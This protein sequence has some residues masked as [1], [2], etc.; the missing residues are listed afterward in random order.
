MARVARTD[1]A[2]TVRGIVETPQGGVRVPAVLT[3]TGVLPYAD[4]AGNRWREL[5]P[6]DEVFAEDSLATL[7]DAPV[8]ELHPPGLVT[9]DTWDQVAVGHN[10]GG[11]RVEGDHLVVTDGLVVQS[12]P[13]VAK[14]V[15]GELCE[16]SAGYTCDLDE[17]PGVYEGEAYDKVQRRI[18][19]NHIALG[20][21]GWAR[22]GR[23]M[24]LRMD[25]AVETAAAPIPEALS[26]DPGTA[27]RSDSAGGPAKDNPTMKTLKLKGRTFRLDDV[28]EMAEAQ[29]TADAMEGEVSTHAA[30]NASISG[31]LSATKTALI[32]VTKKLAAL[33][34]QIA[35][36]EKA[37]AP[38]VTEDDVPEAV[39]DSIV[40]K[41]GVLLSTA[42][43][44][45]PTTVKLD[46]LKAAEIKR[47]VVT[48]VHPTIKLD[49]LGADTI[50]GLY[51]GATAAH[52][53][54]AAKRTDSQRALADVA[55][56]SSDQADAAK[57]EDS[58]AANHS[59]TLQDR[60][61][62]RGQ[63]PLTTKAS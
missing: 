35:A 51:L 24:A 28:A 60:L 61:I 42:K 29:K 3:R 14:V 21:A 23:E 59:T 34:V 13:V 45:L 17:T 5:R 30:A 6:A 32:E 53:S 10:S 40:A 49:G 37:E 41:R 38:A 15:S 8:T 63:T 56:P 48:H 4:A 36:E 12:A 20:P 58:A 43:S 25:G 2:G 11:A 54:Q 47:A 1:F 19:Y 16:T 62:K 55:A 26:A 33:E 27:T 22:G 7:R 52:A 18:R 31:E 57:R 50:E 46:G 9:R 39:Q 44:V